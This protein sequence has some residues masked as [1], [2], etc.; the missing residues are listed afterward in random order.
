MFFVN[1]VATVTQLAQPQKG[2]YICTIPSVPH[3][4]KGHAALTAKVCSEL[5][6]HYDCHRG[7]YLARSQ[8]EKDP[9]N[10]TISLQLILQILEG[11]FV[12][13]FYRKYACVWFQHV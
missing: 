10:M 12:E 8:Y 9:L 1:P 6:T 13:E 5:T 4:N 2:V 7:M 3:T 11:M